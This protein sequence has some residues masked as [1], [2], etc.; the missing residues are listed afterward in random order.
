MYA[1]KRLKMYRRK[2]QIKGAQ[3]C[4]MT[5]DIAYP[6]LFHCSNTLKQRYNPKQR[7]PEIR[8]VHCRRLRYHTHALQVTNAPVTDSQSETIAPGPASVNVT[9]LVNI[10]FI[11]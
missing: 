7:R 5:P 11:M 1:E 3:T 8:V 4:H 10:I 6:H 9:C 2:S